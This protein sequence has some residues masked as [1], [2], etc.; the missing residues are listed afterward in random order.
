MVDC[1]PLSDAMKERLS[2]FKGLRVV[3]TGATGLIG[4]YVCKL[5]DESEAYVR[6]VAH[7]HRLDQPD[8]KDRRF[9]FNGPRF[10]LAG[11]DLLKF[12]DARE[13]TCSPVDVVLSCAGLTG[14]VG[15]TKVDPISYVTLATTI[16]LNT[17]HAAQAAGVPLFGFLS[18]TTVYPPW[19]LPVVER[20][21][22]FA[23][24]PG[25]PSTH[26]P[27]EGDPSKPP[28]PAMEYYREPYPLYAGIGYAKRF[29]EQT[30]AYVSDRTKT[31]CAIVR[32][33]GAYGRFDNFD[34]GTSHVVPGMI[35]R[36]LKLKSGYAMR[37]DGACDTI[38]EPFTIWGDGQ[39]VRDIV[40]A[41]DVALG[42]LLATAATG[43]GAIQPADP[44]NIASGSAISTKELAAAVL[45]AAGRVAE[46]VC[47]PS[48]PTALRTR[49]VSIKKAQRVLG[50]DPQIELDAGLHDV[51][52]FL[53]ET[54]PT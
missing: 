2:F 33:S 14:G 40:H 44:F 27:Y 9:H 19:D 46:I 47:D 45:S 12:E 35:Q 24:R 23:I 36:A 25:E 15:L 20:S 13:A 52:Q 22:G 34:E 32:P 16:A 54:S 28:W 7:R 11:A 43:R 4:S 42:L 41:Q 39:D 30:C 18:S 1:F 29:L 50:Y 31:K 21:A 3:V 10:E 49:R 17:L 6:A 37:K 26:V 5:L 8:E 53:R 51:V 38:F 48:K